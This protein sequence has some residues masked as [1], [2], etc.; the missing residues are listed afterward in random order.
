LILGA[1]GQGRVQLD[2]GPM[3][4]DPLRR[5]PGMNLS[6]EALYD[7]ILGNSLTV[8]GQE[9]SMTL[10]QEGDHLV[11][12]CVE[13]QAVRNYRV[14]LAEVALAWNM[15]RGFQPTGIHLA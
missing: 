11:I 5:L 7:V 13:G 1:V 8:P 15:L 10:C 2:L 14:W 12:Q 9:V 4:S 3:E 6:S